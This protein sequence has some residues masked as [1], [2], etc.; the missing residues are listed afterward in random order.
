M[1]DSLP[2]DAAHLRELAEEIIVNVRELALAGLTPATSSNFS[3]RRH[4][5]G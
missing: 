4:H 3:R 5:G 2:Y 1:S